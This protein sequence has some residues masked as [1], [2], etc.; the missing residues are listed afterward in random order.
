MLLI[1]TVIVVIYYMLQ[2]MLK[3]SSTAWLRNT[4]HWAL[5]AAVVLFVVLLLTGR[6]NAVLAVTV[7]GIA[8]VLRFLPLLL[9][10]APVLQKLWP[11]FFSQQESQHTG[12]TSSK[13]MSI[14]EAYDVLGLKA[15]ASQQDILQAHR[16]L[17]QKIHPDRGGSDY[18]A[19][20]INLA[21]KTLLKK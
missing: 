18:L 9:R 12:Q 21:K 17:I 15:D 5:V 20:K 1:I 14:A 4:K 16:R 13:A 3:A 7:A 10:Y 8:T 19:A 6:L 11:K 2:G